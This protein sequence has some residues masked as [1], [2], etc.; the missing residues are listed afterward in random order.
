MHT[1]CPLAAI[2]TRVGPTT[3]ERALQ[4]HRASGTVPIMASRQDKSGAARTHRR[5]RPEL[6]IGCSGWNYAT[7]KGRFYPEGLPPSRWLPYY[8][9]RFDTVEANGTFYRL[10]SPDVFAS[11]RGQAPPKFLMAVKASR[12]LTHMKRLRDP[13]EPLQRFFDHASA[14]GPLLGPVLYQLPGAFGRDLSRLERFLALLPPRLALDGRRARPVQHVM[15]FRD[16]SWYVPETFALLSRCG[17]ALCL[18]DKAGSGIASMSGNPFVYVRFHGTSGQ[19]HGS[20]GPRT[21]DRWAERLAAEWR[22]GRDV[23][24]Y[25]NNDPGAVAVANA[26]ALRARVETLLGV[27]EDSGAAESRTSADG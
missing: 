22:E 2:S 10:P 5:R 18:H 15:E 19:Y 3:L 26:Q 25:F 24:A 1:A 8:A 13:E 27:H 14:L 23:Y 17:V 20:Y 9:S 4:E 7:W 12:Y 6:R 21:L 11:W 16:P